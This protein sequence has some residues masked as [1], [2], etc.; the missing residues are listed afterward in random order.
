MFIAISFFAISQQQFQNVTSTN[1]ISGQNGLGHAAGWGDIDNDG[2]PELAFSNQEG[3]GF[4]F[5]L[6]EGDGFTNITNSAGLENLSANKIIFCELTGDDY[7][8]LLIRTRSASQKLFKSNGDG[9]FEDIS[10]SS[11]VNGSAIYSVADF[12]N[13]GLTD[14]LS[15]AEY[16][17]SILYNNGDETFSDPQLI[18]SSIN[19]GG[20]VVFDYNNDGLMDIYTSSS[21]TNPNLLLQNNGDGTFTNKTTESGL[22]YPYKAPALDVG[23]YNNDG[24]PDIYIGSYTGNN[25]RNSGEL[26]RLYKNNGDGTFT[27]VT[28]QTNTFGHND[29]RTTTFTDYNN[30]G[31][32][33]IFSSHHDFYT[34]SNSMQKSIEGLTFEE[35][36]PE[37]GISGEWMGDYFGVAWSDFNLDGAIDFFAAG[38]IDKY[39]LFENINC[40]NTSF[41]LILKGIASNPNGI[42]ARVKVKNGDKY[43]NR[44]ILPDGGLQDYSELKLVIGLNGAYSADSLTVYWP[45]GIEQFVGQ[46]QAGQNLVIVEDTTSTNVSEVSFNKSQINLWP[47]PAQKFIHI[48]NNQQ[49]YF[50]VSLLD[51]KGTILNKNYQAR[52]SITID[53]SDLDRGIYVAR[54]VTSDKSYTKKFIISR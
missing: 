32:L 3:D 13:D 31:W 41:S 10:F 46:V 44:F 39:R 33:D 18:A 28:M 27:D 9:T 25:T 43:I 2:D 34:Y 7:N 17:Y 51:I 42:G 4:W 21:T 11:G 53:V 8:D 26:C 52:K 14:L 6:N 54:V 1:G 30:D 23:D 47:N 24:F 40:P 37:L 35:T 48:L 45:S 38:H 49:E 12:D 5:Y 16:N 19:F 50:Q 36:G 20:V 22:I 15:I 29:T